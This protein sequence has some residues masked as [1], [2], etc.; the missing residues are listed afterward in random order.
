MDNHNKI[1]YLKII[2]SQIKTPAFLYSNSYNIFM[3]ELKSISAVIELLNK[4]GYKTSFKASNSGFLIS[5]CGL[6]INPKDMIIDKIYRFEVETDMDEEAILFALDCPKH[7]IRGTYLVPF[8][9]KASSLE[10]NIIKLFNK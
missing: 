9:N 1:K 4:R 5:S 10:A 8:G 7:K 6:N 2:R 3:N